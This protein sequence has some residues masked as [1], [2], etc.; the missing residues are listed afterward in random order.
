MPANNAQKSST[1][2]FSARRTAIAEQDVAEG[3]DRAC[4]N[5]TRLRFLELNTLRAQRLRASLL[6]SQQ[7]FLDLLPLLFH[8]NHASLPGYVADVP[9]GVANFKVGREHVKAARSV[10]KSFA[11]QRDP[12]ASTAIDGIYLIGSCGSLAH[13]NRS[14]IDIWICTAT[15]PGESERA[16][17]QKKCDE[18]SSWA[19]TLKIE[20]HFFI[21]HDQSFREARRAPMDAENCGRTQHYLLLDELYRSLIVAA[22]NPPLWWM[23]PSSHSDNYSNYAKTLLEKRHIKP[24]ECTDFG[25][26]S[27]I[28]A[29]EFIS[30]GVW[31]LYKGISSPY[32]ALLK[33]MLVEAYAAD[34]ELSTLSAELKQRIYQGDYELDELDP[35]L[36]VYRRVEQYLLANEQTERLELARRCLY[37]KVGVKLSKAPEAEA[38]EQHGASAD[39]TRSWRRD[40]MQKLVAKWG[41]R[42][43]QLRMLDESQDWSFNEVVAEQHRLTRELVQSY[44]LLSTLAKRH[45]EQRTDNT[46]NGTGSDTENNNAGF[47]Q[48]A[49]EL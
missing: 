22:G 7:V 43:P 13:N 6:D 2:S 10:A 3:L 11:L 8:V 45:Q 31:Q 32:K 19:A 4:L 46:Q 42:R 21:M 15:S 1:S 41:W 49:R 27:Q 47:E 17:L 33:L 35:Y 14:D 16:A 34:P 38:P 30:A 9:C 28:P 39:S 48:D 44:R 24:D 20:A 40:L 29:A 25:C 18:I 5:E 36:Q 23:V 12:N 37:F 26:A